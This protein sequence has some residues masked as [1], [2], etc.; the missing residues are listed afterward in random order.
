MRALHNAAPQTYDGKQVSGE[1]FY[2][3]T[4][5]DKFKGAGCLQDIA[6]TFV[7]WANEL[8]SSGALASHFEYFWE[9]M[10]GH[11]EVSFI[12]RVVGLFDAAQDTFTSIRNSLV[13]AIATDTSLLLSNPPTEADYASHNA[14]LDEHRASFTDPAWRLRAREH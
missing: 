14:R 8:D 5:C 1:L 13:Q 4:G 10:A 7:Q 11:G 3:H 12:D 9:L 6:E 2:N